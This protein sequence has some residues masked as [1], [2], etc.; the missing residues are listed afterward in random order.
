MA[1]VVNNKA[2]QQR[3]IKELTCPCVR[4]I[5]NASHYRARTAQGNE[6]LFNRMT[7]TPDSAPDLGLPV[8]NNKDL[9]WFM[10][11]TRSNIFEVFISK[12]LF[13]EDWYVQADEALVSALEIC[14]NNKI[15]D[16]TKELDDWREAQKRNQVV[17]DPENKPPIK[18]KKTK[19]VADEVTGDE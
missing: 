7:R 14:K 4:Y 5:G 11:K 12:R 1:Y 6:Y 10:D 2:T 3:R 9:L 16:K 8:V 19:K 18:Q 13:S 17:A 15:E